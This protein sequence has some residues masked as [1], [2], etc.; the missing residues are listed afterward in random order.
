MHLRDKI[1]FIISVL[2]TI[3]LLLL[4]LSPLPGWIKEIKE[5]PIVDAAYEGEIVDKQI[6]NAYQGL[7][8]YK[9]LEYRIVI[10]IDYEYKGEQRHTTKYF[11][12][13]K[14]TYIS[15]DIGDWFDSHNPVR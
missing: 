2:C 3:H 12:V 7:F 6:K 11:S 1:I 13:N 10:V 14:E 5:A 8:T 9:D 15:Y 4:L